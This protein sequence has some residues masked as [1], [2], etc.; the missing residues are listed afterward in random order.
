MSPE[1][2]AANSGGDSPRALQPDDEVDD[3]LV[4]I[5]ASSN[6]T[7]DA[8]D[9]GED[10][11]G[12]AAE[13][14]ASKPISVAKRKNKSKALAARGPTAL[15]KNRGNGFEGTSALSVSLR[16]KDLTLNDNRVFCRSTHDSC[17]SDAGETRDLS[18]VC[19]FPRAQ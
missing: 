2:S 13:D 5:F 15:P 17:R 3:S 14:S 12:E 6:V 9:A 4:P 1:V 8:E 10:E 7:E 19:I 11:D 18:S 16:K